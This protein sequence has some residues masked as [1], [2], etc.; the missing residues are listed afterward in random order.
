[1]RSTRG[2]LDLE[3]FQT[4]APYNKYT[5]SL[6]PLL[7]QCLRPNQEKGCMRQCGSLRRRSEVKNDVICRV[8]GHDP[9][10]VRYPVR[11]GFNGK[12]NNKIYNVL[13]VHRQTNVFCMYT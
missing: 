9:P 1:M 13:R 11:H 8:H 12:S 10:V 5:S 6:Q 2:L 7:L 3:T 4:V